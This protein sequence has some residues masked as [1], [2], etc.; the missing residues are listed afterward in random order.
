MKTVLKEV[1]DVL[2]I[3]TS[4]L[5]ISFSSV[6]MGLKLILLTLSIVYTLMRIFKDKSNE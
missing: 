4:T 2:L 5:A 6:E 3:N 1:S